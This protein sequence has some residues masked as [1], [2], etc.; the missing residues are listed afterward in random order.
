MASPA[1]KY[2]DDSVEQDLFAPDD[3][4][5]ESPRT[6][7]LQAG[8]DAAS[9]V[10]FSSNKA[11]TNDFKFSSEPKL[12]KFLDAKPFASFSQHW[13]TRDGKRS[14]PCRMV[15]D[16][17]CPLCDIGDIPTGRAVFTVVDLSED[18]PV[19]CMLPATSK[20]YKQLQDLNADKFTGP[21]DKNYWRVSSSKVNKSTSYNFQS[22]SARDL[23]EVFEM[24]VD[25][26]EAE[27]ATLE[28]LTDKVIYF[29]PKAELQGIADEVTSN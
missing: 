14:F 29:P 1:A 15:L 12:I 6:S 11:Y 25:A 26:L 27:L 5:A 7:N 4:N 22:I 2:V 20:L 23:Q 9:K 8:W 3:E 10:V 18:E 13:I 17:S 16:G 19:V 21:L 24:D 28:P